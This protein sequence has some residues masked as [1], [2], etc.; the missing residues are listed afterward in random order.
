MKLLFLTQVL[1]G[2]DAVLGFVTRW[3]A[4]LA[5]GCERVRVVALSVGDVDGLPANVDHRAIGRRG[6]IRRYLRWRRAL[7]EAF[8]DGFD[9]VLAHMVPRY[10][11]LSHA[12]ARRAGAREFLWYTHGG[13]DRRLRRA[14]D[15]VE[16]VFSASPDSMRV[17]TPKKVVTGHGIDLEH[18]APPPTDPLRSGGAARLL[19]VGRLTPRK[20]PLTIL[21]ALGILVARG[22]D[23]ELDLVGAG[24][25][26]ADE[27]YRRSVEEAIEVGGLRERVRLRGN[28]PYRAVPAEFQRAAVVVNA[29]FTGSVDKVVLEAMACGRPVLTCNESFDSVFDALG[30][31]A[32]RLTFEKRDAGQLADRVEAF[33]TLAP[34]E[35]DT[36]GGR[37]RALVERDHE[38]DRLMA[39]LIDEMGE[40]RP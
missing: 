15:L 40:A 7:D 17:E 20:D 33:L 32:A 34:A 3:V 26:A 36:L 39:R 19:S 21:A 9:T 37:L 6:R 25:A 5:R 13:V 24:L 14:V 4:G 10:T 22:H 27:G 12:R 16:K 18:F 35:R 23:V 28:V 2:E 31:D 29:S 1:D 8:A 11:L 30:P 38:V